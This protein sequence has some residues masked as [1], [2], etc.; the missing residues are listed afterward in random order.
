MQVAL[1]AAA[2][3]ALALLA[4]AGAPPPC[5]APSRPTRQPGPPAQRP[6]E[7]R[8]SWVTVAKARSASKG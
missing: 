4:L 2:R 6:A 5:S 7:F 1:R 3:I 8:G